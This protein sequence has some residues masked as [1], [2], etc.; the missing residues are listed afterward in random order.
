MP[1]PSYVTAGDDPYPATRRS[2]VGSGAQVGAVELVHDA[3]QSGELGAQHVRV[4]VG[5]PEIVAHELVTRVQ[6]RGIPAERDA[7]RLAAP[8]RLA[9][10]EVLAHVVEHQLAAARAADRVR[11]RVDVADRALHVLG[12]MP[13]LLHQLDDRV[14]RPA[15]PGHAR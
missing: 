1:S 6:A 15:F 3:W 11:E 13:R 10:P 2:A 14:G 9:D 4:R 5:A 8:D 12:V 7:L